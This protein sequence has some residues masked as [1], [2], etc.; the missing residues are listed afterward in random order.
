[1][2]QTLHGGF[3]YRTA[4]NGYAADQRVARPIGSAARIDP[5]RA[6]QMVTDRP[7]VPAK[8]VIVVV[9]AIAACIESRVVAAKKGWAGYHFAPV[10]EVG[11]V[12]TCPACADCP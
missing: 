11:Y 12:L 7:R 10:D 4:G 5:R 3:R 8:S 1:M 6:V 2:R 9:V